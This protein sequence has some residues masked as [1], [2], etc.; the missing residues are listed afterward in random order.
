MIIQARD[1]NEKLY[2]IL[3]LWRKMNSQ[4][5]EI[6]S[7]TTSNVAASLST[8]RE[9]LKKF[10]QTNKSGQ[11]LFSALHNDRCLI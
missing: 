9:F 7:F 6:D 3:F 8:S 1:Q 5:I 11:S 2:N 10:A 4:C